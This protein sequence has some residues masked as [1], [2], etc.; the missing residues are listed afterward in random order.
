MPYVGYVLVGYR[1]ISDSTNIMC[2]P[3]NYYINVQLHSTE[4]CAINLIMFSIVCSDYMQAL[5]F[6]VCVCVCVCVCVRTA[7]GLR[8][9]LGQLNFSD[10]TCYTGQFENGLFN[11]CGMLVFP[12][13]SRYEGDFVQGKF[14]GAGVFT[15]FDGMKF[16]GEFKSGCVDGYGKT[17][18]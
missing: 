13:G 16:E 3:V 10:G 12:D 17:S 6:S 5:E 2:P 18:P 9:G 15:R 8:H 14:H 11:C 7:A 1:Y 4:S